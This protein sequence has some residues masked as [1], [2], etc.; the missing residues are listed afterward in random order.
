MPRM[1]KRAAISGSSSTLTLAKRARGSSSLAALSKI[2]AIARQGPHQ[3]AQKST[4][5][6]ISLRSTCLSKVF[7]V[8]ATGSPVKRAALQAP[9]F[10][11]ED[12][13]PA[14]MRLTAEQWGQTAWMNSVMGSRP[15]GG[16]R[17]YLA[18]IGAVSSAQRPQ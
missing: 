3:G 8:S 6:G 1:P 11:S 12:G 7:A 17:Q 16:A 5:N 10:A 18:L 9:H 13:R 4:I 15:L 2:G 14:G